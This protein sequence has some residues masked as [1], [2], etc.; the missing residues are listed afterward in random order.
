[1]KNDKTFYKGNVKSCILRS[2]S[3]WSGGNYNTENSILNAYYK[4]ID[5]SKNYIIIT[6]QFFISDTTE[7]GPK[8]TNK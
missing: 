8:I 2:I 6:N 7:D 1:M 5:E 4:L 3:K